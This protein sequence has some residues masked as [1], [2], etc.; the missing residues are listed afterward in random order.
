VR[1][2][3]TNFYLRGRTGSEIVTA[4][5][6]RGLR[7]RGHEVAVY[8]PL[9][10]A[11]ADALRREGVVAVNSLSEIPWR[12]DVIHGHHNVV[13][14]AALMRFPRTPALLVSQHPEHWIEGP[15]PLSEISR[16]FAVSEACR[17]RLLAAGGWAR[18][19]VQLLLN[20]VDLDRF[21]VRSPLPQKPRKALVLTKN[22][23]H[24]PEV[25]TAA[26]A[27][28]LSLDELG[29][30][31]GVVVDDL[32]LRL[33]NYDI[34]F[35]TGRMALEALASGCS[36]IIVDARGLAGLVS[37]DVV[38]LWRRHNFGQRLLDR[39]AT[40]AELMCEISRYDS[41]DAREV[42]LHIRDTASLSGYLLTIETIYRDLISNRPMT[43]LER[44]LPSL[45]VLYERVLK[46]MAYA[47]NWFEN[48]DCESAPE[49]ERLYGEVRNRQLEMERLHGEMRN[50]D[51]E[52]ERLYGEVR[53]RH[54][55]L[56][57][58]HGEMCNRN[59][60][61]ERLYGEVRNRHLELERLHG[62]IRNRDLEIERQYD[63]VRNR[64]LEMERL[65]GEMRDRDLEIERLSGEVR[66]RD[67]GIEHL[68]GEVRI[69]DLEIER[70]TQQYR[71]IV[72][73]TSWRLT[74]PA[75]SLVAWLFSH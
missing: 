23:K 34:V 17:D 21:Q 3:I 47:K 5:L 20:A 71:G 19:D 37:F 48:L 70:L 67:F 13:L 25:R 46:H 12:P 27:A 65:H 62:E 43:D 10:G 2:L 68:R 41:K 11:T 74:A 63:E 56:E 69:R 22:D 39:P 14:W 26:A 44:D 32:H 38:D 9:T 57:R 15:L 52:I 72:T 36:V 24:L 55:E 66:N 18:E 51:L 50:R 1:I 40:V 75:R 4:E 45:S 54:L 61:I 28:N 42:S 6:A 49:I 35:S 53:N 29:A 33:H 59:L 30:G 64:Q 16:V 7:H 8:S 60:E 31:I 73:S 58:L